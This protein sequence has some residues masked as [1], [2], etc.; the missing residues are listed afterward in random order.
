MCDFLLIAVNCK[1]H[2]FC[3]CHCDCGRMRARCEPKP[4]AMHQAHVFKQGYLLKRSEFVRFWN[5]R[6]VV[7]TPET[8]EWYKVG[9]DTDAKSLENS[10]GSITPMAYASVIVLRLPP[11]AHRLRSVAVEDIVSVDNVNSLRQDHVI[12]IKTTDP[13]CPEILLSTASWEELADWKAA[14]R[15]NIRE[16]QR[17]KNAMSSKHEAPASYDGVCRSRTLE[18]DRLRTQ[19]QR[20]LQRRSRECIETLIE[21]AQ[22]GSERIPVVIWQP[23]S[24]P[25]CQLCRVHFVDKSGLLGVAKSTVE[26]PR[27]HHCRTCGNLICGDCIG[28]EVQL[29]YPSILEF[30]ADAGVNMDIQRFSDCTPPL[31]FKC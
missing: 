16:M 6:Y 23:D 27:R 2:Q 25:C 11:S 8:L 5:R 18:F 15:N 14:I 1:K 4:P 29:T 28:A 19:A 26:R 17:Y 9:E 20:P 12:E 22:A 30:S 21:L 10:D 7:L 31:N 3:H 13:S 24:A